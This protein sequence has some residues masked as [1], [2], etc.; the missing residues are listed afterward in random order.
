M[1]Y[2]KGWLAQP[3][4][5]TTLVMDLKFLNLSLTGTTGHYH[6]LQFCIIL[7]YLH[8]KYPSDHMH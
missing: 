6:I 5:T 4:H 3:A 2:P 7:E 1:S 8:R